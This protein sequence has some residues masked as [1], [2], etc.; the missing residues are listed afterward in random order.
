ME[1]WLWPVVQQPIPGTGQMGWRQSLGDGGLGT[2][3]VAGLFLSSTDTSHGHPV[4]DGPSTC[5]MPLCRALPGPPA[6]PCSGMC[7]LSVCACAGGSRRPLCLCFPAGL[8]QGVEGYP[9]QD[10]E[11]GSGPTT[12]PKRALHIPSS[13]HCLMLYTSALCS[14]GFLTFFFF[15]YISGKAVFLLLSCQAFFFFF[16]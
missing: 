4:W 6:V 5:S 11:G 10:M 13:P 14:A 9:G 12:Y 15:K 1:T 2:A 7:T 3:G 16:F 8:G